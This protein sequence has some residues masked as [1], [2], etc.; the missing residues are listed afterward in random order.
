MASPAATGS[1]DTAPGAPGADDVRR[2]RRILQ[3]LTGLLLGM[4]V[5]MLA[6]TVVSTSLPVIVH[7]LGDIPWSSSLLWLALGLAIGATVAPSYLTNF[8]L[9]RISSQA[10]AVISFIN[11][12]FTLGMSVLILR[13]P[14]TVA[15]LAGTL[16]VLLGVGLYT[17]LDQRATKRETQ[18]T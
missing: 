18:P 6:S 2:H 16:L 10:N 1:V 8:A 14:A 11:P 13:I 17:W 3:A 4:F 5:S 7:D 12:V 15:D 9:S